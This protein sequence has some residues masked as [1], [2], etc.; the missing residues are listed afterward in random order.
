MWHILQHY[1]IPHKTTAAIKCLYD[2]S[3]SRVLID[4]I[5]SEPFSI[6]TGVLPGDT[7]APFLFI[8]VLDYALFKLPPVFGFTS[9]VNLHTLIHDLD[10]LLLL[11]YAFVYAP[12]VVQ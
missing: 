4:N 1:G 8:T 5:A 10:F 2:Q 12:Y 9:H 7:L 3:S 6:T 11:L